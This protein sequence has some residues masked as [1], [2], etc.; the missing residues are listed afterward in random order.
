[1]S[2]RVVVALV[3]VA[4]VFAASANAD[5]QPLLNRLA[6]LL[7]EQKASGTFVPDGAAAAATTNTVAAL[8]LVELGTLP[9]ASSSGGFVYGGGCPR[10]RAST[11][12]SS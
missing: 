4:S 3:L 6:A 7:T 9:L 2:K 10:T 12:C 11:R 8:F 1:M 5:A